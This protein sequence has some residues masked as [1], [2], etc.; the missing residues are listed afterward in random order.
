MHHVLNVVVHFRD[1]HGCEQCIDA[2][3]NQCTDY[4]GDDDFD[5]GI[6]MTFA[7]IV[8]QNMLH[9]SPQSKIKSDQV[10]FTQDVASRATPVK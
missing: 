10:G 1:D 3:K 2:T 8:F 6:N 4:Y 7:T 5:S 9:D